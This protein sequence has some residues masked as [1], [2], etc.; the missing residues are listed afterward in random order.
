MACEMLVCGCDALPSDLQI[1]RCKLLL[2]QETCSA[3]CGL[4]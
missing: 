4:T 3:A 1:S 2:L